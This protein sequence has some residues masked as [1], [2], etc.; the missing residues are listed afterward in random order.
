MTTPHLDH[1]LRSK[2]ASLGIVT[3]VYV[4]AV[5]AA[6]LWLYAGPDTP[7]LLLDTLLADLVA[8]LVV[9]AGSRV[10]HNSS[11]YDAYWS[12]V[13]PLLAAYWWAEREPGAD[14]V[15]FA[16]AAV[17][18][19]LWAV[20]LTGNW[21]YAWPG[22]HHEDWRYPMLKEKDPRAEVAVDLLAIHVFPTLQVFAAMLPVYAVTRS[23]R[24]WGW[25]DVAALVLGVGAVLL[26]LVADTQQ[27]R[28]ARTKQPGQS[29]DT[30]LWAWSRHPNYLGEILMWASLAL[31][32]L[33]AL[34]G[35]W[36]WQVL[37]VVGMV[38]MFLGASIPMMEQRSLERRPGYQEVVDR[39]PMLLPRP[40]RRS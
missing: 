17:V 5:A 36:W 18:L 10:L 20:R 26:Q 28:F 1:P 23:D 19:G 11:C 37:G 13:P 8:T 16:L 4:A 25:L 14:A 35:E 7:Y 22:L 31:F 6:A 21:V 32:G 34:P 24:P 39:V 38:A 40:P 2:G 3:G 15:R 12:V 29:L 33:S 27:H 30:G 9:F